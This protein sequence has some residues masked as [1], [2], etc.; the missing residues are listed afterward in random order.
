MVAK[1]KS[2]FRTV[3]G[4]GDTLLPYT[5]YHEAITGYASEYEPFD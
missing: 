2:S 1:L 5:D 4:G 3:T